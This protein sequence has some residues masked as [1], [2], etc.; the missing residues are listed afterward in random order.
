MIA[1]TVVIVSWH[2]QYNCV[3]YCQHDHAML[4][5]AWHGNIWEKDEGYIH[6]E[7]WTPL[8]KVR[9]ELAAIG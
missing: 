4:R 1:I 5:V 6:N 7:N 9:G 3:G 2:V 8:K